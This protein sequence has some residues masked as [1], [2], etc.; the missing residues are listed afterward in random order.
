MPRPWQSPRLELPGPRR[1]SPV[2]V[3]PPSRSSGF[4]P[5]MTRDEARRTFP[6]RNRRPETPI[7]PGGKR[8]GAQRRPGIDLPQLAGR[9]RRL[10]PEG[11]P[12]LHDLRRGSPRP[13]PGNPPPG[14]AVAA[15]IRGA[16]RPF[17]LALPRGAN[18]ALGWHRRERRRRVRQRSIAE[19]D[20]PTAA[21]PDG[22]H[23]ADQR[24]L[25]ERL[26]A[27]IRR[28]PG[29][30]AALVLLHLDD[31]SYRQIAEVLGISESNVGARLNRA[32]K[33]LGPLMDEGETK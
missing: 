26:Y 3:D 28:L 17:D 12:R 31:L 13:G 10:R 9:A 18:T 32:K 7:L 4:E 2:R 15:A 6:V 24:E 19:I 21:G 16:V 14:L 5:D 8:S 23:R 22:A 33:A 20:D 1:T 11:G 29:A 30:D 25:V 27:A